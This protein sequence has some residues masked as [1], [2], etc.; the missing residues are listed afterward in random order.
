MAA[1]LPAGQATV[2]LDRYSVPPFT[3]TGFC[4][5]SVW[6]PSSMVTSLSATVSACS[7][8]SWMSSVS[9]MRSAGCSAA[10]AAISSSAPDTVRSA[11]RTC[12]PVTLIF[13][14]PVSLGS[15]AFSVPEAEAAALAIFVSRSEA[16][17]IS[18]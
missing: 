18:F 1:V 10:S 15:S 14:V 13:T 2:P 6:P 3:T 4:M 11:R 17:S 8:V 12:W 16:A 9:T 7:V 5:V